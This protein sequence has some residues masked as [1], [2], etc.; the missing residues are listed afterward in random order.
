MKRKS[1]E[2]FIKE[3][4]DALSGSVPSDKYYEVIEYYEGYF[5]SE[6]KKGKSE[7]EICNLLGSPRLIAKSIIESQADAVGG[8]RIYETP[9][10]ADS[11]RK[12]RSGDETGGRQKGWHIHIDE[13][14][15]RTSIAFGRLDFGTVI[16]KV[17]IALLLVLLACFVIGIVY[18]GIKVLFYVVFPVA[19]I[20]LIVN[21]IMSFFNRR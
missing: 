3:L 2:E 20:L 13:E 15:G 17:V 14:T 16:G 4:S 7:E 19:L 10:F 9:D 8:E 5:R 21:I 12:S 18:L 6:L 1:K 11:R